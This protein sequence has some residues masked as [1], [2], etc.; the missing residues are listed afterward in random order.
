MI[1]PTIILPLQIL[2]NQGRLNHEVIRIFVYALDFNCRIERDRKKTTDS[3][4]DSDRNESKPV[5]HVFFYR[6]ARQIRVLRCIKDLGPNQSRK[7]SIRIRMVMSVQFQPQNASKQPISIV[8]FPSFDFGSQRPNLP[9]WRFAPNLCWGFL[10]H[11]VR[12]LDQLRRFHRSQLTA[13]VT[14]SPLRKNWLDRKLPR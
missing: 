7:Q 9:F 12:G 3:S 8:R 6:M 10:L 4:D 13:A 1:V 5:F 14:D 11:F 2:Q